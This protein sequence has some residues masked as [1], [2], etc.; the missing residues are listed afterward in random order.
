M[1]PAEHWTIFS[2]FFVIYAL[3]VVCMH[4][5]CLIQL[6]L[7]NQI[8]HYYRID[9]H[10]WA[11]V[12]AVLPVQVRP[13]ATSEFQPPADRHSHTGRQEGIAR[14]TGNSYLVPPGSCQLEI[15]LSANTRTRLLKVFDKAR[16]HVFPPHTAISLISTD[17]VSVVGESLRWRAYITHLMTSVHRPCSALINAFIYKYTDKRTA[18]QIQYRDDGERRN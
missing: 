17:V 5:V 12:V 7:P 13:A 1:C 14:C 16:T 3:Y 10:R 6:L 15:V 18:L 8:N 2:C 11:Q 9:A 4:F